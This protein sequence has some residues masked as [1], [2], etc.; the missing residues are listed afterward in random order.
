M[1]LGVLGFAVAVVPLWNARAKA[2]GGA[3]EIEAMMLTIGPV[4]SL[5]VAFYPKDAETVGQGGT[6]VRALSWGVYVLVALALFRGLRSRPPGAPRSIL[7]AA[8][9][10]YFALVLSGIGGV[11]PE[12]PEAYWA[13]PLIVMAVLFNDTLSP[14][15]LASVARFNLRIIVAVG[16]ALIVLAPEIAFN[17]QE[18][19]Q[20]LG[21]S[22][23]RE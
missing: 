4:I 11:S 3:W 13:T 14:G 9:A 1:L 8:A 5:F 16:F 23:L 7:I 19:R 15:W 2:R 12:M 18:S 17:T 21:V 22:R 6:V 20:L 10:F